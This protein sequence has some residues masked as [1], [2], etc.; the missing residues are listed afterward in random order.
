MYLKLPSFD[1][2]GQEF[3]PWSDLGTP[4]RVRLAKKEINCFTIFND[5]TLTERGSW[6]V[7]VTYQK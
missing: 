7:G 3:Y 5:V 1:G 4:V 6:L 2:S